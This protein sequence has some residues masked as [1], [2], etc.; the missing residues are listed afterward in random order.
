MDRRMPQRLRRAVHRVPDRERLSFFTLELVL[1]LEM[2][3]IESEHVPD[4]RFSFDRL[5][6]HG[7]QTAEIE[8]DARIGRKVVRGLLGELERLEGEGGV[9]DCA[10]PSVERL[11]LGGELLWRFDLRGARPACRSVRTRGVAIGEGVG[12]H[13]VASASARGGR[14]DRLRRGFA[15]WCLVVKQESA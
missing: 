15:P 7:E 11:A 13:P 5:V 14:R 12:G 3:R 10:K 2:I 1:C 4:H 6:A 9:I 8:E